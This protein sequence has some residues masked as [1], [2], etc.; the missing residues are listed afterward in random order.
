MCRALSKALILTIAVTFIS[1]QAISDELFQLLEVLRDN[2]TITEQQY[3]NL[4]ASAEN[5]ADVLEE[6]G[7]PEVLVNTEGGLEVSTYNGKFS[8]EIGGR[9]MID[10]AHYDEDKNKLGD[11]TELRRARLEVEGILFGDWNYEFGVDFAGGDADVKDAYLQYNGF[12][13]VS[14]RMGQF[15]E[16]FSLEERTSS[17]YITFME[18]SLPNEFAPGRSIGLGV[19]TLGE[20]WT[21]AAGV[22]GEAFDDDPENE[23]DEGWGTTGRITYAP[24]HTDTRALHFGAAASYR[25]PD[26]SNEIKLK[27]RPESHITSTKYLDTGDIENVD[28][29]IRFG[30]ETAGVYGPLSLQG[31]YIRTDVDRKLDKDIAFDG[32]Y[33]FGSWFMTGESRIYKLKKGAFGRVKPR[34]KLG[35]WELAARYS[36]LDLNDGPIRGGKG[37]NVTIGLNW[38]V[39]PRVRFMANYI[40]VDNDDD[41]DADGDVEGNDDPNIFQM[42]AQVD[43]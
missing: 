6:D 35:A 34:N 21:A 23:R 31:E 43:F 28:S 10:A 18:R 25:G 3:N 4:K 13:P 9:L 8:F 29:F 37:Q 40:K 7:S 27:T 14:I 16:P 22:F 11:G 5:E 2:G 24:W 38:Y 20:S 15:K 26:E 36:T 1:P 19:H 30:I 42:R 12:W 41:A 17:K 33:A 32:W 39:N